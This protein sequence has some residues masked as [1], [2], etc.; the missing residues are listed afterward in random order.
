MANSGGMNKSKAKKIVSE[1]NSELAKFHK[2]YTSL[3]K[4]IDTIEKGKNSD[5][6]VGLWSGKKARVWVISAKTHCARDAK[7]YNDLEDC[8]TTLDYAIAAAKNE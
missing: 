6:E 5:G 3:E 2:C 8:V 4:A 1:L 7:L